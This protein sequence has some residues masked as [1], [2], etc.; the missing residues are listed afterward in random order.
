MPKLSLFPTPINNFSSFFP[1]PVHFTEICN[2]ALTP[3]SMTMSLSLN[4][5]E[6][7]TTPHLT[8]DFVKPK[9]DLKNSK[10]KSP[11]PHK[12][13]NQPFM[14]QYPQSVRLAGAL[15]THQ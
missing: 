7:S 3:V 9:N 13:R 8:T 15:Y 6:I 1:I 10:P 11:Y 4:H 14:D 2:Q 12:K 5:P